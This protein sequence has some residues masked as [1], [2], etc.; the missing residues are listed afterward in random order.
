MRHELRC[1]LVVGMIGVTG[2]VDISGVRPVL[3][4]HAAPASLLV[5]W[6]DFIAEAPSRLGAWCGSRST[7]GVHRQ[8]EILLVWFND[9]H[10]RIHPE[11]TYV[12]EKYRREVRRWTDAGRPAE[13]QLSCG[14]CNEIA[15]QQTFTVLANFSEA[16]EEIIFLSDEIETRGRGLVSNAAGGQNPLSA[17]VIGTIGFLKLVEDFGGQNSQAI[18]KMI[19]S[20]I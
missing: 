11:T 13:N 2:I 18:W 3:A 17:H 15:L 20:K 6:Q 12:F 19:R 16:A 4:Q 10:D 14:K 1:I 5:Q 9:N 7:Y 8:R